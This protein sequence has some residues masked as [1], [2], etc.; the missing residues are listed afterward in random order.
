MTPA[1]IVKD[2]LGARAEEVAAMLLPNGKRLGAEWCAGS[3]GGEAGSSLKVH[4]SGAKAG[5][6]AD[7][8]TGQAG[9]LL[10]LWKDSRGISF[11]D[12]LKQA[13]EWLGLRDDETRKSFAPASTAKKF[14]RPTLDQHEPMTSGGPVFDYLT[15]IRHLDADTLT[16]YRVQQM[17]H[18]KHGA[19]VV[20][21]IFDPRGLAV[22]M[23]KYLGVK[24]A[25][26]G[27][28]V[29]WATADS[30]PRLFGWQAIDRN[31]RYVVITEGE[32]DALTVAGWG[33]P[34][35]SVPSGVKNLDWVDHDYDA[36]TRFEKIYLCTD[37]DEPGHAC[38]EA[39]AERLGRERCFRVIIPGFKDANEAECSGKFCGEDF[40]RVMDAA[41]TLDPVELLN[42]SEL[43]DALWAELN[44]SPELLGSELPWGFDRM[45]WRARPGEVTIWTGWSGH[46][47]SH[48][49]NQVVLHDYATTG[50]RV[51]IAS[52][53]MPAAKT[54]S[55]LATMAIGRRPGKR[56]EAD[57]V[58]AWLGG[59]FWFYNVVG[60]KP[61]REFLPT[62]A[63]AVRRY[64]IKRIVIDSLLRAG[65]GEDDYDGQKDF[66]SALIEFAALHRVHIH[67][68]A[69][70]RKRDDETT[71]PGKLDIRGTAAITDLTNNGFTF[72]RN[73]EREM[74]VRAWILREE[75]RRAQAVKDG[76]GFVKATPPDE[77]IKKPA[78]KLICWKNRDKGEEP[79]LLLS[80]NSEAM[81][82]CFGFDANAKCYFAP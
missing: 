37:A 22:E 74:E 16:A 59:G 50:S 17:T 46:G 76:V 39:I 9:D 29:I 21:P 77:L 12:A 71:P 23:V 40:M 28:K 2:M 67:L 70:S 30:R 52:F 11:C 79:Y 48:V 6:W 61:W 8:S 38:A 15:K 31:A 19:T 26:D 4:L 82:F 57:S 63:Y 80:Y 81:Q 62:F 25:Q 18:S 51:L 49:L 78:A 7:F 35:L 68:V 65:I 34:A 69:H 1:N 44:P 55:T 72:W 60:V 13:K 73:K 36:L 56:E 5:V 10:D 58:T 66:V 20:F 42:A 43:N 54:V 41:K 27:K 14:V 53:E 64:G 32:I 24:R 3:V 47:K 33:F 45:P 75:Q